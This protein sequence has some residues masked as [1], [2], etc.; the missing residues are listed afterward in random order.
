MVIFERASGRCE[1]CG[2]PAGS[3]AL[4]DEGWRVARAHVHHVL[5]IAAGGK[6]GLDNLRLL[7]VACHRAAHPGNATLAE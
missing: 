1:Q 5:P 6:H 7:C 3:I 4:R 2:L